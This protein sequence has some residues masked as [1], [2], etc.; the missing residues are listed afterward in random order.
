METKKLV[1]HSPVK[2]MQRRRISALFICFHNTK[3]QI[4]LNKMPLPIPYTRMP[5][6]AYNRNKRKIRFFS[7]QKI[8]NIIERENKIKK[9]TR[10]ESKSSHI[11]AVYAKWMWLVCERTA[12]SRGD[13]AESIRLTR[14]VSF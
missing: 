11:P 14:L 10:D 8:T 13:N 9:K 6:T 12:F 1:P 7:L 5:L 4:T 3:W 2:Q